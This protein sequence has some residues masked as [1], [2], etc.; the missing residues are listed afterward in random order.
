MEPNSARSAE[1]LSADPALPVHADLPAHAGTLP[2]RADIDGLRAVA[3][4]AVVGFHAFPEAL[5]GGFAGV[6][7]FFVISGY[8]ISGIILGGLARGDFSFAGFYA[9]R[10]RRI[11][12]AL[13]LVL[14]TCLASGWFLLFAG[15]YRALGKHVAGGAGFISNLLLWRESG[16]FDVDA[17]LKPLLHLW[18][19]GV[20]EQFYIFWPLLLWLLWKAHVR[21]APAGAVL[22][23]VSFALN[24]A[25]VRSDTAGAFYSPQTRFWELLGGAALAHAA[26]TPSSAIAR[27]LASVG[28]GARAACGLLL[29]VAGLF[30]LGG[31]A[32][33]GA[34]ALLPVLGAVL[35]ISAA[36][37]RLNR[38]FL[39]HPVMV[40]IG[41]ISFPL[42]LWHWPL[43]AFA[44]VLEAQTPPAWIRVAAVLLAFILSALTYRFVERPL[45]TGGAG[46]R[47]VAWLSIGMAV[48]G[49]AGAAVYVTG[50]FTQRPVNQTSIANQYLRWDY[51]RNAR[52]EDRYGHDQLTF[53]V[54]SNASPEILLLGDSHVNQLY[55]GLVQAYGGG[56]GVLSIGNGAP[57]EGL[58]VRM[59]PLISHEW[60]QGHLSYPRVMTILAADPRLRTVVIGASWE[61]MFDGDLAFGT[62]GAKPQRVELYDLADARAATLPRPAIEAAFT[63]TVERLL[64]M[65]RNVVIAIDTPRP[66]VSVEKCALQ[67]RFAPAAEVCPFSK[68]VNLERQA[69]FRAL[70]AR[71]AAAHPGQ[72]RVFDPMPL[73]C[74][75]ADC[76]VVRGGMLLFRDDSHVTEVG[77]SLLGGELRRLIDSFAI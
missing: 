46:A 41:L 25:Y 24:L 39:A 15:E 66:L 47:K 56:K 33:P 27:A 6:D 52:C 31:R 43:L 18:S 20:E 48:A 62:P 34:W 13:L 51:R 59:A 9:R 29:I 75:G 14:A 67:N 23:V 11:F 35:L 16:Y 21:F 49:L 30:V 2:Y 73:L 77:S 50:G 45:R 4:L 7:I 65:Q 64:A 1:R 55:P 37:T 32:F 22:L 17:A 53:C 63:R 54:A 12:P 71:L 44:R 5:P 58:G 28:A 40:Y 42:Y 36:G 70:A 60:Q 10:V 72:I 3:V 61:A 8:L 74:P 57:L 38:A 68:Q 19:L 69:G 76:T 26:L